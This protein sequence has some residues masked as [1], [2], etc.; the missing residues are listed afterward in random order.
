MG[1]ALPNVPWEDRPEGCPDVLWRS[2][3]NSIIPVTFHNRCRKHVDEKG[4]F[5][6][7]G[8]HDPETELLQVP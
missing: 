5:Y 8:Q 1:E 6:W 2:E 3:R 7:W 4:D